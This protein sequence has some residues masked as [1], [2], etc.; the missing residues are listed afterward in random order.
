MRDGCLEGA[1]TDVPVSRCVSAAGIRLSVIRCPP[2]DWAF[3]TVGL[4]G[5]AHRRCG[6]RRGY[7]VPHARAATGVGAP[8]TAVLI[9]AEGR[10]QPAPAAAQRPVLSPRHQQS[11]DEGR[12]T[13]HRRGFKQFARPIF[14]SPVAP[15]WDGSPR[16]S[17]ELR[18]PP[19]PAAHVEGGDRPS[20]TDLEQR[21]TRSA[22]PPILRVHSFTCDLASH[23]PMRASDLRLRTRAHRVRNRSP[24][25]GR[26]PGC[27]RQGAVCRGRC[28]GARGLRGCVARRGTAR[29][30]T[31]R[32]G[33]ARQDDHAFVRD[34]RAGRRRVALDGRKLVD[35]CGSAG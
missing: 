14:P 15:R 1:A 35:V 22:E 29:H 16:V 13:R 26:N 32:H 23:R 8:W 12:F 31:A 18:T 6:P 11:T 27:R 21:S 30:G 28:R 2:G 34:G 5:H 7:R 4:P 25:P 19:S 17:L 9:A 20:S 33:T 10:A 3:L 24:R